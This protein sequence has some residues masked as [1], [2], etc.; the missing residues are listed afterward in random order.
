VTNLSLV[1]IAASRDKIHGAMQLRCASIGFSSRYRECMTLFTLSAIAM[2]LTAIA[3]SYV[4]EKRLIGPL[5]ALNIDMLSGYRANLV[6]FAWH[7]TSVLMVLTALL[8]AWPGTP[9]PLVRIAGAM[10]LIAGVGDAILTRS[11]H[12]GWPLLSAAGILTLLGV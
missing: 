12:I 10:W 4:G 3:H 1:R 6:R 11:K 8:V 2:T 7:F 5:L 9:V